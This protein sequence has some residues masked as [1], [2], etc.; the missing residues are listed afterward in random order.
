M[1][2][3]L[4]ILKDMQKNK[5]E[6]IAR[7]RFDVSR[8]DQVIVTPRDS[9]VIGGDYVKAEVF[10]QEGRDNPNYGRK[11]ENITINTRFQ[12]VDSRD[13]FEGPV[14]CLMKGCSAAVVSK[15]NE[16]LASNE[17]LAPN[18]GESRYVDPRFV[19]GPLVELRVGDVIALCDCE[20]QVLRFEE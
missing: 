14:V 11:N 15:R 4:K 20:F 12:H 2:I 17:Q 16:A 1:T 10:I 3:V 9:L 5:G 8:E 19:N 18:A 13:S 7:R 6:I